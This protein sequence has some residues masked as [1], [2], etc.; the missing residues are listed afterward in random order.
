MR[1]SIQNIVRLFQSKAHERYD[2]EPVSQIRHA[3]LT[4]GLPYAAEAAA[5]RCW[6]DLSKS[7]TMQT[8]DFLH[9]VPQMEGAAAN[10]PNSVAPKFNV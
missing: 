4:A 2:G 1:L 10:R 5:L 6:E 3:L 9:F 8:P 7:A